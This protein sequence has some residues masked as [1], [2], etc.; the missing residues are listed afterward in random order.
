MRRIQQYTR[1]AGIDP[2]DND[3]MAILNGLEPV[4][5]EP[6]KETDSLGIP[7]SCGKPLCAPGAHHP[8][9]SMN[10]EKP[11]AAQPLTVEQVHRAMVALNQAS[12][13]DLQPTEHEMR[14]AIEAACGIGVEKA[15]GT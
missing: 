7:K 2:D 13:G 9:C 12:N 10:S 11:V 15:S 3:A 1:M 14:V 6:A 4:S 8:L 5:L